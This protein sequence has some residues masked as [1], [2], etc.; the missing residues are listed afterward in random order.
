[1]S[2]VVD[3]AVRTALERRQLFWLTAGL[4]LAVAIYVTRI[5]DYASMSAC[6]FLAGAQLDALIR[7]RSTGSATGS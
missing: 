2:A 4:L 7:L 5:A 3:K 1:V 6:A